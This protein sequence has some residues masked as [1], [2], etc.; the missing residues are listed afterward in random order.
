MNHRASQILDEKRRSRRSLLYGD[1]PPALR[2]GSA[3]LPQSSLCPNFDY[4]PV[5]EMATDCG[6]EAALS[7]MLKVAV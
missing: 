1:F 2:S 3:T 6:D 7:V 5:P 4:F